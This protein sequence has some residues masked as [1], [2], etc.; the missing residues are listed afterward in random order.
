MPGVFIGANC[1]IGPGAIVH[2]NIE[3]NT[4]FFIEKNKK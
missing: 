3:D 1:Q 2:E 4:A